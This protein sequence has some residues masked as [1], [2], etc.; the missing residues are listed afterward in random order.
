MK[1]GDYVLVQLVNPREKF[2]GVLRDRDGSGVTV[3][4]ISLDGFEGWLHEIARGARR[5]VLPGD[6]LL[7]APPRRA[8]VRST[9]PRATSSPSRIGSSGRRGG[10]AVLPD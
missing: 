6:R 8:G 4:G 9:R 1:I 7:S 5:T 10:R 2:W 3:R